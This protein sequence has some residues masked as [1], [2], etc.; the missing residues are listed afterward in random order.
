MVSGGKRGE[1][2]DREWIAKVSGQR[3]SLNREVGE[4]VEVVGVDVVD[5]KIVGRTCW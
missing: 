1:G 3:E 4:E 5:G 2:G